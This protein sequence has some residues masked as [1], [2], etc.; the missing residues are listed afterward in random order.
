MEDIDA[1]YAR[2]VA[3]G[4]NIIK[5]VAATAWGTKDFYVEDPDGYILAFGGTTAGDPSTTAPGG[6]C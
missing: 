4:A 5:P 3:H 1:F 2:C 6:T